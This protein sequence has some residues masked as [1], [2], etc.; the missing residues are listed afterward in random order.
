[1]LRTFGGVEI[2]ATADEGYQAGTKPWLGMVL[3]YL[4]PGGTGL[5][6]LRRARVRNPTA[7]AILL[8]EYD[9]REIFTAGIELNAYFVPKPF[10]LNDLY[11]FAG[12]A[13]AVDNDDV[14][15]LLVGELE[16]FD[17]TDAEMDVLRLAVA[18]HSRDD[19]CRLR[20]VT[21]ATLQTQVHAICKKTGEPVLDRVVA[22]ILRKAYL[23]VSS[24]AP[25]PA[26]QAK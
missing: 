17:L 3:D 16:E 24:R 13:L 22:I 26:I 15:D 21:P 6:V 12:R 8:T 1:M 23:V 14:I 5:E 7:I 25:R 19:I 2:A 9:H 20:H 4:L 18:G 10:H 11:A